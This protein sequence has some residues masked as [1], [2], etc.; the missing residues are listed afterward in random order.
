MLQLLPGGPH[1]ASR[2]VVFTLSSIV[3]LMPATL[4]AQPSQTSTRTVVVDNRGVATLDTLQSGAA[5]HPSRALVHFRPGAA[6]DL[7]P[8]SPSAR[9]F[10]GDRD[11][12]LVQNPPGLSVGEVLRRYRA[13]P[14]VLYAEPDYVVNAIALTP[15]DARWAEQWDMVKIAAPD[16]WG[17]PQTDAGDVIVAIIDTGI[18]F[19]HPDLQANVWTNHVLVR[20]GNAASL[21]GHGAAGGGDYR[22]NGGQSR[23]RECDGDG[24]RL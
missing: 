2:F 24:R 8:G 4:Q 7:L 14:N 16:A 9:A 6:A 13:N 19:D 5:F 1:F 22:S 18:D 3:L 10:P 21:V 15:N 17:A 20:R 12:Y 11:L 23:V